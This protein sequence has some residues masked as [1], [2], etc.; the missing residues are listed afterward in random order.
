MEKV[1]TFAPHARSGTEFRVVQLLS[2]LFS[3]R[4][5]QEKITYCT[6]IELDR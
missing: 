3:V 4:T 6:L 1:W 5:D 2:E